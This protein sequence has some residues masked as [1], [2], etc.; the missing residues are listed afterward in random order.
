L[1]LFI[2]YQ[3]A[4]R[5]AVVSG[6][7]AKTIIPLTA[8][9]P[10]NVTQF[11]TQKELAEGLKKAAEHEPDSSLLVGIGVI[12]E[13]LA[14]KAIDP[15][16]SECWT[17]I[18]GD[19]NLAWA[20]LSDEPEPAPN[21]VIPSRVLPPGIGWNPDV[22]PHDASPLVRLTAAQILG[23]ALGSVE[24]LRKQRS[25][26]KLLGRRNLSQ[27]IPLR[28]DYYSMKQANSLQWNWH[29]AT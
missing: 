24:T 5:P 13:V 16:Q 1:A 11:A 25:L 12:A 15:G 7:L 9:L 26:H 8:G 28:P 27:R 17:E 4:G 6:L 23:H 10:A 21:Q 20:E 2:D 3:E 22:V 29:R 18:M 19:A 14:D